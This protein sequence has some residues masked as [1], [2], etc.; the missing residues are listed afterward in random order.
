MTDGDDVS[1]FVTIYSSRKYT[2]GYESESALARPRPRP[3][4]P[5]ARFS[6]AFAQM[7]ITQ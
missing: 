4:R 2:Q 3:P 1:L 6:L 5:M 7:L